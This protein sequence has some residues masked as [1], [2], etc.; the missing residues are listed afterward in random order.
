VITLA[1]RRL[2]E[3]LQF[4]SAREFAFRCGVHVRTVRCWARG[5]RMPAA[6]ERRVVEAQYGIPVPHWGVKGG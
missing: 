4:T 3:I 1:R 6:P 5:D 2:L